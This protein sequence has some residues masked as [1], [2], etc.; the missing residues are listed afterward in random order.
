MVSIPTLRGVTKAI[1][2]DGNELELP[3]G[4]SGLDAARAIGPRLADATAAVEVDGELRDLRLPLPDGAHLRILRVGDAEALPVLRHST[5]HLH[6]RGRAA[7]LA[8]HEGRDR[9]R[10]RGRLLLR[11]RVRRAARRERSGAHRGRDARDPQAAARTPTSAS[12]TTREEA[13]ARF[14]RRGRDL[15][16]RDRRAAARGRAGDVLRAGRL[17]RPL[18]RAASAVDEAD[19]G[20]QA[21]VARGRVLARRLRQPDADAHLRHGVLRPGRPR[22]APR[23]HRGGA[24]PRPPPPRARARPLPPQ[25]DLAR[26]AV[27]APARDGALQRARPALARAQREPRLRGGAR[28]RSSTAPSSGSARATGTTTATRCS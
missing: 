11:L 13:V 19:Q 4:A 15:Q 2:P 8:G 25:R 17:R 21:H 6:G 5:A 1:L 26:L 23:A 14:A 18:P 28:R 3:D 16:G 7:P 20:L 12:S 9:A 22:R 24:P 10:D 27:L